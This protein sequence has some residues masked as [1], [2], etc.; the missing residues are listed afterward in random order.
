MT[1]YRWHNGAE[2]FSLVLPQ[3]DGQNLGRVHLLVQKLYYAFHF[4][5]DQISDK[6]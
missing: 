3:F 6:Q 4:G 2:T 5:G 1:I